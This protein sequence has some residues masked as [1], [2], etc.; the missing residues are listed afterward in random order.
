M[1]VYLLH[2]VTPYAHA[3]HYMGWAKDLGQRLAMHAAGNGA[4]LVQVVQDAGIEWMLV[5][6]WPGDRKLERKLK[7]RKD[8]RQLC[9]VCNP[10]TWSKNG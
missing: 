2:F 4:R 1:T 6:T 7:N 9:P 5:R 8:T 10:A 3:R